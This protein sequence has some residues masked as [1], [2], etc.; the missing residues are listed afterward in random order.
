MDESMLQQLHTIFGIIG[1]VVG[2]IGVI[3]GIKKKRELV[4][5]QLKTEKTKQTA[6]R[7]KRKAEKMKETESFIS[8]LKNIVDFIRGK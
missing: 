7:A 4:K 2:A 5:S 6:Y 3:Y 8:T 1:Y